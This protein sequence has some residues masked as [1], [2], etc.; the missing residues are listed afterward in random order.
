MRLRIIGDGD[1]DESVLP[2]LIR[3]IVSHP[4]SHEF[5]VWARL[6]GAGKGYAA[7][8]DFSTRVARDL[9][10][11]GVAAVVDGDRQGKPRLAE[12]R[13]GRSEARAAM[14][15]FPTAIGCAEPHLEAWLLDDP[16][17]VK[18]GLNLPSSTMLQSPSK[19]ENP[20]LELERRHHES[21]NRHLTIRAAM[22]RIA[23]GVVETRCGQR[24]STGFA[25][26]A[27]ELRSE[28]P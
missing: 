25:A 20:K 22:E 24:D 6:H 5:K 19:C 13:R 14:P 18:E 17:A 9:D 4:V 26:F 12:L 15:S 27:K 21:A 1:R 10:F 23:A 7:K 3:G 2:A 16:V 28:F 8:L 11:D